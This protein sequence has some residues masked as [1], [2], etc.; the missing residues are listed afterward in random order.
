MSILEKAKYLALKGE[1]IGDL[2]EYGCKKLLYSLRGKFYEI[3]Y[4][5]NENV[6]DYIEARSLEYAVKY[7]SEGIIIEKYF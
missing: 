7:Y 1:F 3:I 5:A 2:D 6:I 4:L